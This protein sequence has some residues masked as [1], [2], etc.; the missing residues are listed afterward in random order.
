M[1][2][3]SIYQEDR[4]PSLIKETWLLFRRHPLYM[5]GFWWLALLCIIAIAAPFIAPFGPHQQA[6]TELLQVPSWMELGQVEYFFGTDDLGRDVLSRT[7]FGARLSFGG[8]LIATAIAALI[9][10]S[11]GAL[12][13]VMKN[14]KSSILTHSLDSVL[15]TPSLILAILVVA[16][17]GPSWGH[18]LLAVTISLTPQ[19]IRN[20]QRAFKAELAK[21]YARTALLDGASRPRV[22][23]ISV[24]PNCAETIIVQLTQALSTA[25]LDIAALGF[26]GIGAQAPSPEWGT[27]MASGIEVVTSAPWIVAVPGTLLFLSMLSV[28]LVGEGLRN[29]LTEQASE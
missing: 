5:L 10:I 13:A 16:V 20:T 4:V 27:M 28:N 22:I 25:L 11:I 8:A 23:F 18:T 19:F 14:M 17:L 7:L 12:A 2:E 6:S 29:V 1:L 21:D 3:Q 24:F 26:L 9:G 15:A